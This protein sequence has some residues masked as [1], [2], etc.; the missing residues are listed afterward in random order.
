MNSLT[1][2]KLKALPKY[3]HHYA[4]LT[5]D[6]Q[7]PPVETIQHGVGDLELSSNLR[8]DETKPASVRRQVCAESSMARAQNIKFE[9]RGL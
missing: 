7:I 4:E 9:V 6:L 8:S 2:L 1:T 5:A 3:I